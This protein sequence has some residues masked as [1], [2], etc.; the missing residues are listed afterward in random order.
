MSTKIGI[1][2]LPNVGKSTLFNALTLQSVEVENYPFTTI[3]PNLGYALIEDERLTF[4]GSLFETKKVTYPTLTF[5]DIAGLVKGASKGEGL[6][7]EF[8]AQIR[9]CDVLLHVVRIFE[10]NKIVHVENQIDPRRDIETINLELIFR[11]LETVEKRIEKIQTRAQHLKERSIQVELE[12][13]IL[14]KENL[15][16]GLTLREIQLAKEQIDY[17][18]NTLFLLTIKPVLYVANISFDDYKSLEN[19]QHYH[20]ILELTKREKSEVVPLAIDF[21]YELTSFAKE[22]R[23]E[24]LKEIGMEKLNLNQV[25]LKTFTMLN[26]ITFFTVRNDESR[27]WTI[28]KYKTAYD[29]AGLIHSDMQKGFIRAEVYSYNDIAELLS[30]TKI[31][32]AGKLRVEGRSYE[33]Q[34]G[35]ILYF[36]FR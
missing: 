31:K 2:G 20:T 7:N 30:E 33:I 27:A 18:Q 26:L 21:E 34:D 15:I 1:I 8:L 25:I 12:T 14:F 29:G 3:K 10:N 19:N 17:A 23:S 11:D 35:D 32:E 5:I 4:L 13:L 16:Q 22:E 36:R 6:G 9:E 28:K 24:F